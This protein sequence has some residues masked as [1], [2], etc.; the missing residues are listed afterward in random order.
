MSKSLH[1]AGVSFGVS[2]TP[3]TCLI[4]GRAASILFTEGG[5][6]VEGGGLI[7]SLPV[8]ANFLPISAPKCPFGFSAHS[9]QGYSDFFGGSRNA[10]ICFVA[11][12]EDNRL[13]LETSLNPELTSGEKKQVL[14]SE[15]RRITEEIGRVPRTIDLCGP[16]RPSCMTI[17]RAFGSL[18]K[19]QELAGLPPN[20]RGRPAGQW[21]RQYLRVQPTPNNQKE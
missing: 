5:W 15:L 21:S 7:P 4:R 2:F 10:R 11:I 13:T 17:V 6:E 16:H 9:G 1:L 8:L 3:N 20:S 12:R 19:A 14:L 18:R